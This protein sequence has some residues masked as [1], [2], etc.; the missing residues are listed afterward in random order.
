MNKSTEVCR[1]CRESEQCIWID[2]P[3]IGHSDYLCETCFN[4]LNVKEGVTQVR[5]SQWNGES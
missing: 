3:T 1:E 5:G 4:K 2:L